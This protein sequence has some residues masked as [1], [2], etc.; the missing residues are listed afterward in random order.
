MN[1]KPTIVL[2]W[3]TS[4][5]QIS[6]YFRGIRDIKGKRWCRLLCLCVWLRERE[7]ERERVRR[8]GDKERVRERERER[9]DR[10][11]EGER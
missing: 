11:R 10:E 6:S 1:R 5:T 7:R 9:G 2:S 3:P 4:L 8:E